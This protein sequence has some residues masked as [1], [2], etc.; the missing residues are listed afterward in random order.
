MIELMPPKYCNTLFGDNY[1]EWTQYSTGGCFTTVLV[2][3]DIIKA[4]VYGNQQNLNIL[5]HNR[6]VREEDNTMLTASVFIVSSIL[7]FVH[8]NKC[9]LLNFKLQNEI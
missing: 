9:F 6:H 3:I 1:K 8:W 4:E 2:E 7:K 5:N